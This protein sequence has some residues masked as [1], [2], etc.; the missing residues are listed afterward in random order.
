[1]QL[2]EQRLSTAWFRF[3]SLERRYMEL[4]EHDGSSMMALCP[5]LDMFNHSPTAEPGLFKLERQRG[6][7]TV[8]AA[9]DYTK[10]EQAFINYKSPA[11]N[12]QLLL[13]FGFALPHPQ[14]AASVITLSLNVSAAQCKAHQ[15]LLNIAEAEA[16][17]ARLP[18]QH[19]VVHMPALEGAGQGTAEMIVRHRLLPDSPLPMALL[20]MTRIQ[21]MSEATLQEDGQR[22]GGSAPGTQRLVASE[23]LRVLCFLHE[24]LS[25]KRAAFRSSVA[26]DQRRLKTELPSRLRY[27]LMLRLGERQVLGSALERCTSEIVRVVQ[28]VMRGL[29]SCEGRCGCAMCTMA[30]TPWFHRLKSHSERLIELQLQVARLSKALTEKV[31]SGD[32]TQATMLVHL[33]MADALSEPARRKLIQCDGSWPWLE[34]IG[35]SVKGGH[36]RL[37]YA[38]LD[39]QAKSGH[40]PYLASYLSK[41][42]VWGSWLIAQWALAD[43]IQMADLS[44]IRQEWPRL[45]DEYACSVPNNEAIAVLARHQPLLEVG[46]GGGY[47][48]SLLHK[49]RVDIMAITSAKFSLE[50]NTVAGIEEGTPLYAVSHFAGL[51]EGGP[52]V[53]CQ[54]A[55]RTLVLMWSDYMG[56]GTFGL[57]CVRNYT[58]KTLILV[59]EW[60]D[61]TLGSSTPGT[62]AHGQAFSLSM[63][64]LVDKEYERVQTVAL[65]N[66][67]AH[68]DRLMVFKRRT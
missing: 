7:V 20:G 52:Q 1:M 46:A 54:H 48:A 35:A 21:H 39:K 30:G 43:A 5:M 42:C 18:L 44:A 25:G 67:P 55:D 34:D 57:E 56:S 9:R 6:V 24:L 15:Q 29:V 58:G 12:D 28:G 23:E 36:Q 68:V 2:D 66:W 38:A 11:W 40:N 64:Q 50:W 53:V 14:S 22:S 45:R 26:D 62:P 27:A 47:W 51:Q 31:P 41:M 59:G 13:S 65:P 10:G 33:W 4:T 49:M 3:S 37:D 17:Q 16:T 19:T 61:W 8:R 32:L 63:Q 60:H